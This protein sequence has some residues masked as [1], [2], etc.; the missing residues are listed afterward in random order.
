MLIGLTGGYCA[1]KNAVADILEGKGWACVDVDKLGHEAI[2]MASDAIR[3]RFGAAVMGRDGRV[4]RRELA[5]IVFSDASALADQEAIVHPI[6]IRLTKERV[7]AA[8]EA[9]AA[10]GTE[11]RV[12]VNAAL[13]HR[14]DMIASCGAVIEVR[15]PLFIRIARGMRRDGTGPL[16]ALRR[17]TRQRLFHAALREAAEEAGR[18]IF[19]LRNGNGR[20]RLEAETERALGRVVSI[21]SND[22][23]HPTPA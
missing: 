18:P 19:V 5:R 6:A 11:P 12:C 20:G 15:A 7:A 9:A 17:I 22:R 3:G 1:G 21:R 8:V 4:D 16:A 23:A 13:L 14:A 2:D 10:S